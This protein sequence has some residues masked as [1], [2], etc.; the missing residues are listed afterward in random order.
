MERGAWGVERGAWGV[1]DLG[2]HQA[3]DQP[4]PTTHHPPR[5]SPLTNERLL[6]EYGFIMATPNNLGDS[7]NLPFGAIAIGL[8][9]LEDMDSGD[10][11]TD[12]DGVGDKQALLLGACLESAGGMDRAELVFNATTGE[13]STQTLQAALVLT[14]R[15]AFELSNSLDGLIEGASKPHLTRA[16]KVLTTVAMSTLAEIGTGADANGLREEGVSAFDKAARQFVESR[17]AALC[18]IEE[19]GA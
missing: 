16:K 19:W 5:D 15:R 4:P 1:E 8:Q 7:L 18:K 2:S 6:L 17:R 3:S 12:D 9:R 14:A 10:A 13:P 11:I